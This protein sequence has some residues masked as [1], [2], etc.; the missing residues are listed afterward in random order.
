MISNNVIGLRPIGS[1]SKSNTTVPTTNYDLYQLPKELHTDFS[2]PSKKPVGNVTVNKEHRLA[3][4]M[5]AFF[6]LSDDANAKKNL[7]GGEDLTASTVEP[8]V[9]SDRGNKVLSLEDDEYLQS[10]T[11]SDP[12]YLNADYLIYACRYRIRNHQSSGGAPMIR[13]HSDGSTTS[14][15]Q[16]KDYP[17]SSGTYVR[18]V[19]SNIGIFTDPIPTY[20]WVTRL[21][22]YSSDTGTLRLFGDEEGLIG[23][24]SKPAGTKLDTSSVYGFRL[25]TGAIGDS[26]R[27][28]SGD[29]EFAAVWTGVEI[30]DSDAIRFIRDP[31]QIFKPTV[32]E[33]YFFP[34]QEVVVPTYDL[35][36]LPKELHEGFGVKKRKPVGSFEVD[37]DNPKTK[38]LKVL[39]TM[40][41]SSSSLNNLVDNYK[42]PAVD[43][44]SIGKRT[45]DRGIVSYINNISTNDHWDI[46]SMPVL[47][48]DK[49][50]TV[51]TSAR[52]RVT[53]NYAYGL[54]GK[55]STSRSHLVLYRS[56]I[57]VGYDAGYGFN[58]S[59]LP[60]DDLEWHTVGFT[61]TEGNN[62]RAF[63]DNNFEEN[64]NPRTGQTFSPE[65]FLGH[66]SDDRSFYGDAEYL[67]V[68][69]RNMTDKE[70]LSIKNDPYQILK[71]T[72]P[73]FYY[74]TTSTPVGNI[75]EAS[76]LFSTLGSFQSTRQM[77]FEAIMIM[78]NNN[79]VNSTR[80]AILQAASNLD[81]TY[82]YTSLSGGVLEASSVLSSSNS[83]VTVV[84]S[85]LDA[86]VSFNSTSQ[87]VNSVLGI[88]NSYSSYTSGNSLI[89][90]VNKIINTGI[91]LNNSNDLTSTVTGILNASASLDSNMNVLATLGSII[92]ASADF[93]KVMG[94]LSGLSTSLEAISSYSNINNLE[95]SSNKITDVTSGFGVGSGLSP[96]GNADLNVAISL[97]DQL[98]INSGFGSFINESIGF[99]TSHNITTIS[100]AE[101]L[102]NANESIT[103]N[104]NLNVNA[105][106]EE[107][108]SLI[109]SNSL[110]MSAGSAIDVS[111]LIS[112]T[113]SLTVTGEKSLEVTS[114]YIQSCALASQVIADLTTEASFGITANLIAQT[115]AVLLAQSQLSTGVDL[116]ITGGHLIEAYGTLTVTSTL[117][118][119]GI[120]SS[121]IEFAPLHDGRNITVRAQQ[122]NV[123]VMV[124]NRN[125]KVL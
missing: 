4:G 84:G 60:M 29:I 27:G 117:G 107:L 19:G 122:R 97:A 15:F 109:V 24:S 111:A 44:G 37:W 54:L 87:M 105:N 47:D 70:I 119:D 67:F 80:D 82:G 26:N 7:L 53:H 41:G 74:S 64:N 30:S 61:I 66:H 63:M 115:N 31:Y 101:L 55:P 49:G 9:V 38:G 28:F 69:N 99:G 88:L 40:E 93:S 120:V 73:E 34:E 46:S 79:V 118:S 6:L 39:V 21:I 94:M 36:Q 12:T 110:T 77:V 91:S 10:E 52:Y 75:I 58:A 68:W 50:L 89:S 33:F 95:S 65:R 51:M 86:S 32:P 1:K 71:P 13:G 20:K 123:S 100:I 48:C 56:G 5:S 43:T 23:S 18:V 92:N 96:I 102:A 112:T 72:V 11:Y 125:I 81:S 85:I 104:I 45:V 16:F 14:Y 113:N 35:Y 108:S 25:G 8:K 42:Y 76:S 17:S 78:A 106:I 90:G 57:N 98:E 83:L 124:Q 2:I 103:N 116:T 59:T 3:K 62:L 22:A 121:A 114:S